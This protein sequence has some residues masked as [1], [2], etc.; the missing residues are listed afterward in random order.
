MFCSKKRC[1]KAFCY[2]NVII[3]LP[4]LIVEIHFEIELKILENRK[5]ISMPFNFNVKIM[6][7]LPRYLV[8]QQN[9]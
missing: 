5:T 7:H 8:K 2:K 3:F 6:N 9:Y 1:I 4:F